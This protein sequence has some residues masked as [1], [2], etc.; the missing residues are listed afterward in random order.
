LP[1]PDPPGPN[2]AVASGSHAVAVTGEKNFAEIE[3]FFMSGGIVEFALI[4]PYS[5]LRASNAPV[6]ASDKSW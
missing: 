3:I 5:L 1:T 4:G 6:R 2:R